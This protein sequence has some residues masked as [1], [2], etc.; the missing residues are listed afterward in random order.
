M[1]KPVIE[2]VYVAGEVITPV[3]FQTGLLTSMALQAPVAISNSRRAVLMTP[4]RWMYIG[5]DESLAMTELAVVVG[6]VTIMAI[7]TDSH[8]WHVGIIKA[9]GFGDSTVTA[10]AGKGL[11]EMTLMVK[12][13]R[14]ERIGQFVELFRVAVAKSAILV[15]FNVVAL[16]TFVHCWQIAVIGGAAGAN[17]GMAR[18]AFNL[19]FIDV[20]TV[21]EVQVT[22]GDFE[23]RIRTSQCQHGEN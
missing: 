13:N 1:S 20:E 8:C 12:F 9:V 2:I 15:I 10:F 5:Q 23:S 19:L 14:S 4:V 11:F 3:T 16:A 18:F 17:I 21:G 7:E 22:G 6:L